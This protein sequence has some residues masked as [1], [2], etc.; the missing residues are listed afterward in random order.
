MSPC[1]RYWQHVSLFA[2]AVLA[3]FSFFEQV[4]HAAEAEEN[5]KALRCA[6]IDVDQSALAGL[7][8]AEL[9]T[10]TS[11]QWLERTEINRLLEEKQLQSLLSANAGDDRVALGQTLKADVLVILRTT[12]EDQQAKVELVVAETNQGLRLLAKEFS[13]G[14][15]LEEHSAGLVALIDQSIAKARQEIRQVVAVPPFVSDDLTYEY[16]YLKSSYA[17][18][19][20]QSLLDSPGVLIVELEE[21]KAIASELALSAESGSIKRRLPIYLLGQFRNEAMDDQRKVQLTL[22]IQQGTKELNKL[23]IELGPEDVVKFLRESAAK[24]AETQGLEA[25]PFDAAREARQL[26]ERAQQF[27]RLGD[28]SEALGLFEASLMLQP[29]QPEIHSEAIKA[30]QGKASKYNGRR[31]DELAQAKELYRR[32]LSHLQFLLDNY[33]PERAFEHFGLLYF[34]KGNQLDDHDASSPLLK[35]QVKL[36]RED[37]ERKRRIS[38]QLMQKLIEADNWT[39][40]VAPFNNL[41]RVMLPEDRYTEITKMILKYQD[42]PE[43]ESIVHKYVL[44]GYTVD[45]MR[46]LEG[47]RFLQQLATHSEANEQVKQIARGML[48]AINTD[49]EKQEVKSIGDP[50]NQTK[51]TFKPVELTYKSMTGDE[52]KL[53]WMDGCIPLENGIDAFY[54]SKGLFVYSEAE[55]LSHIWQSLTNT[56]I[57]S[58]SY[59]GQYVWVAASVSRQAA[60]VWVFD[61]ISKVGTQITTDDGL[62]LLSPADIPGTS[63]VSPTAA[64]ATVSKGRA[65]IVGFIGRTWLADVRFSPDG[66]HQVKVFH[67]AKEILTNDSKDVDWHNMDLA[68][69]PMA[70]RT[71]SGKT[72]SGE[73]KQVVMISRESL[74][75]DVTEH[76]LL[77]DPDD[78][79]VRVSEERWRNRSPAVNANDVRDGSHY[80]AG[81]TPPAFDAVGLVR[82]GFPNF[83]PEMVMP[84]VREGFLLFNQ[85]GELNVAG[86]DW[87]RGRMEDGRLKSFGPVP[88]LYMNRYGASPK[89]PSIRYERGSFQLQVLCDS[90]NFGTI[91]GCSESGGPTGIIQVLFDG[92]GVTLKEALNGVPE[93][94]EQ[95]MS[96]PVAQKIPVEDRN[97]WKRP[98][99]CLSLAYSPDDSLIV[100]TSKHKNAAVQVWNAR[101]G[102]LIA[103]LLDDPA[104]MT[105]VTFSDDGK[106][107]ATGGSKGRVI[108]WDTKTLQPLVECEGQSDEINSM[109]FSWKGDRLAAASND[110]TATIWNAAEGEKLYDIEKKN[111]G[112]QWI[113]F[114]AD[115]SLVITSSNASATAFDASDGSLIG[116]IESIDRPGGYLNDRSLI[117]VGDDENN[118]L[119]KWDSTNATSEIVWPGM[120]GYPVAVSPDGSLVATYV[121]NL[122]VDNERKD[123]YRVEIWDLS[124]K[125][126]LTSVDGILVEEFDFTPEK[127]ALLIT[128]YRGGLRKVDIP[129]TSANLLPMASADPVMRTWTDASGKHKREAV[130]R[131]VQEERVQLQTSQGQTITIP[132]DRL[133]PEDQKYVREQ[134]QR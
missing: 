105:K 119:I 41:V 20:E 23:Q 85:T 68:F 9:I 3:S 107:F 74:V 108:I 103:N 7:V 104:G 123:V 81:V 47:R 78:L 38:K 21:A 62:P 80:Y 40:S 19:L 61:P 24:V 95:T 112:I 84:N 39:A 29:D 99:H 113:G 116:E 75:Y 11:E 33:P 118:T 16:D 1:M 98:P 64:L 69:Q 89:T 132:L 27:V 52:Q 59:D 117:A 58:V 114:S 129:K 76:A 131:Q 86:V 110:R 87:Q 26:N 96:K 51:L 36:D 93:K 101:D 100:T 34:G 102:Q 56:R 133:S 57:Q 97:F 48:D 49:V 12:Q 90:N 22:S 14:A 13:L 128:M 130:F 70:V 30:A 73:A 109:A 18:L 4:T 10:R 45:K 37:R 17:K 5:A 88:W 43:I 67:E 94:T 65:I 134:S 82:L 42:R 44:G 126:K 115:D 31:L 60:Q 66:K 55:G 28:W 120:V 46:S 71:L 127:D 121:R 54:N 6:L 25:T 8:E 122:F 72:E 106:L 35:Q 32:A 125:T 15:N 77:V 50:N 92:S 111:M 91:I 83:K 79:S 124:T 63:L 53:G 2:A